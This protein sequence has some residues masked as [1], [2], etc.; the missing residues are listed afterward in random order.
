M[1]IFKGLKHKSSLI[2]CLIFENITP[3][4]PMVET[5]FLF[6]RSDA[7]EIFSNDTF[8]YTRSILKLSAL[9]IFN[10]NLFWYFWYFYT[11]WDI[12]I[13]LFGVKL[14]KCSTTKRKL[15][16]ESRKGIFKRVSFVIKKSISIVE[17]FPNTRLKK[18]K[19]RFQEQIVCDGRFS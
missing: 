13:Y 6:F 11:L 2:F 16:F 7:S 12:C 9:A 15:I 3:W 10:G 19:S 18:E 1:N 5:F 14:S 4:I 17:H 8:W